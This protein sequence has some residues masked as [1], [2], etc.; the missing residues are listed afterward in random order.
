MENSLIA[1]EKRGENFQDLAKKLRLQRFDADEIQYYKQ[2]A[3]YGEKVRNKRKRSAIAIQKHFRGYIVRKVIGTKLEE[4]NNLAVINYLQEKRKAR[5]KKKSSLLLSFYIND[6]VRRQREMK[7]VILYD[8]FNYCSNQIYATIKGYSYR[9]SFKPYYISYKKSCCI[10]M[11]ICIF[12]K[13]KQILKCTKIQ[14]ILNEI[15]KIKFVVKHIETDEL[16]EEKLIIFGSQSINDSEAEYFNSKCNKLKHDLLK[17]LKHN[18]KSFYDTFYQLYLSGKW[19]NFRNKNNENNWNDLMKNEV[20]KEEFINYYNNFDFKDLKKIDKSNID[21]QS[22][23][24]I[25]I[26]ETESKIEDEKKIENE[27]EKSPEINDEDKTPINPDDRIIKPSS[28]GYNLDMLDSEIQGS[29]SNHKIPAKNIEHIRRKKPKY[30]ARKAIEDAK[31]NEKKPNESSI[32]KDRDNFRNFIKSVKNENTEVKDKT[33]ES[34][35]RKFKM[36]SPKNLNPD[37]ELENEL[38]EKLKQIDS[39]KFDENQKAKESTNRQTR[40]KEQTKESEKRKRL[41]DLEKSPKKVIIN[42]VKSKIDCW[43]NENTLP[44][45]SQK[46][47]AHEVKKPNFNPQILSKIE[48]EFNN[49]NSKLNLTNFNEIKQEKF[50]NLQIAYINENSFYVKHYSPEIYDQLLIHLNKHYEELKN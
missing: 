26:N 9:K 47:K 49:I 28:L 17:K 14:A 34:P 45:Y 31:N 25:G 39:G 38:R 24:K 18:Y 37:Q 1:Y 2:T 6:Y 36:K 10:I 22:N 43:G 4:I 40:K 41:H 50:K 19:T 27:E 32:K 11:N 5:I 3:I 12:F 21:D 33:K 46:R 42:K 44:T 7:R 8:Y 30:D 15:N 35:D 48:V 16:N 13:V 23:S 29:P 20:K